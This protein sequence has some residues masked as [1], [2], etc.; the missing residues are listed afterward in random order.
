MRVEDHFVALYG[1]APFFFG[2]FFVQG[3]ETKTRLQILRFSVGTVAQHKFMVRSTYYLFVVIQ[4]HFYYPGVSFG[5]TG[6][7]N[8]FYTDKSVFFNSVAVVSFSLLP[9]FNEFFKTKL[10]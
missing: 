10:A 4:H 3:H 9:F 1:D 7:C 5:A 2:Y 8:F 6:I